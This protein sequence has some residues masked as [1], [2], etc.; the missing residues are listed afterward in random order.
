M[1][2]PEKAVTAKVLL[3]SS[4]SSNMGVV[5]KLPAQSCTNFNTIIQTPFDIMY[6]LLEGVCRKLIHRVIHEIVKKRAPL[7]VVNTKIQNFPYKYI[8]KK[9]S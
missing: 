7:S 9:V 1:N 5:R 2:S 4:K 3:I 8:H 6:I